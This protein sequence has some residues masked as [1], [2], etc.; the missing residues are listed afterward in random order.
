MSST[1]CSWPCWTQGT[2]SSF[3]LPI[4]SAI[5]TWCLLAGGEPVIAPAGPESNF[6]LSPGELEKYITPKTRAV[7]LNTPSN[8]TGCH[9]SQ[10][11]LDQ[12]AALCLDKG[13]FVIS[14]EVYDQLVFAPAEAS[15]LSTWVGEASGT[16]RRGQRPV[17]DIR[18]DRLAH[19]VR[20]GAP[21]P[22]QGPWARYR[23]SP[24]PGVCSFAQMGSPGGPHRAVG[25]GGRHAGRL[26]PGE[27]T[28][29]VDLVGAW[30]DVFSAPG[31][32]G[33]ST[34]SRT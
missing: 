26:L 9:Y 10:A 29:P 25:R 17:Q 32:R 20:P 14:D 4:G 8:P 3:R 5:R 22:G 13:V 30:P 28:W 19:R 18:H 12:L 2:R 31:R 16:L 11:E 33:P 21:G 6:K 1:T 15:T 34:S 27:G 23:A 7:F 24:L